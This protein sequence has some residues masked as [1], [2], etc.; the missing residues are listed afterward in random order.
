MSPADHDRWRTAR[1]LADIGSA[2]AD[3]LERRL[4]SLTGYEPLAGPDDETTDL[5]PVLATLNRSGFVTTSSQPG[6]PDTGDG[7]RQRAA[8][9]G[10]ASAR[11]LA[12]VWRLQS[13]TWCPDVAAWDTPG[14]PL[15]PGVS[16]WALT[17]PSGADDDWTHPG[18][19]VTTHHHEVVTAFGGRRTREDIQELYPD[20]R[21]SVHVSLA[22]TTQLTLFDPEWGRDGLLWRSLAVLLRLNDG[23]CK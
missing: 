4:P 8:V 15:R 14:S 23:S 17:T 3:W 10:F 21:P 1:S 12:R 5:V 11:M 2:T 9:T 20:C 19:A 6:R 22:R 13:T 7:W 18:I 16:A